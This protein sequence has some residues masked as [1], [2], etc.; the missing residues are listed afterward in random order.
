MGKFSWDKQSLSD[1]FLAAVKSNSRCWNLETNEVTL[2][3][4]EQIVDWKSVDSRE[5][6]AVTMSFI[7]VK[8]E[9]NM[10]LFFSSLAELWNNF[11][12]ST[13]RIMVCQTPSLPSW[14]CCRRCVHIKPTMTF[15][16]ASIAGKNFL[17]GF[18]FN[19]FSRKII[20]IYL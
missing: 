13:G 1:M 2:Y 18:N 8:G 5:L 3:V 14:K 15:P 11:T 6:S 10:L 12:M 7:E 9:V 19:L 16:F 20:L 17:M 4:F